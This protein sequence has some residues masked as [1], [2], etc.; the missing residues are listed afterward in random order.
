MTAPAIPESC[1]DASAVTGAAGD[2]LTG[3]V[4][5]DDRGKAAAGAMPSNGEPAKTIDGLNT[6]SIEKALAAI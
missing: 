6:G 1:R 2:A 3:K 5:V 4:I